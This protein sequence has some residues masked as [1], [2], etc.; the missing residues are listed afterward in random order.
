MKVF[1]GDEFAGMKNPTPGK[2]YKID[3]LKELNAKGLHGVFGLV[4]PDSQ[5]GDYHYHEKGEHIIVII[6]GEGVEIIDGKETSVKAG[7]VLYVPAGEKHTIVNR[8]DKE[9]R[10]LGFMTR[11]FGQ[12]DMIKVK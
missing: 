3:V 1:K 12:T 5:G 2:T 7:D 9:L 8:S 10:Y 6:S 4:V 11:A